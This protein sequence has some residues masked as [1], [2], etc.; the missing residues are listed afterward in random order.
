MILNSEERREVQM[1]SYGQRVRPRTW[2]KVITP[3]IL[4]PA[5]YTPSSTAYPT[6]HQI[7]VSS[8]YILDLSL[9]F[10]FPV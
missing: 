1:R 10:P 6:G 4:V 7:L 3:Q 9:C 5:S 2:L 8:C